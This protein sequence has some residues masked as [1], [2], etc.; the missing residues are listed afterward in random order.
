[1]NFKLLIPIFVLLVLSSIAFAYTG[2]ITMATLNMPANVTV[3]AISGGSLPD[4][5]TYF[6]RIF[7][8]DSWS[9][10]TG[11]DSPWT[12]ELNA[13]T[14]SGS[15]L[16]SIRINWSLI[17]G[18]YKYFPV[19]TT[20]SGDYNETV[21]HCVSRYGLSS[22]TS[23]Y[24]FDAESDLAYYCWYRPDGVPLI[25]V[26]G[27]TSETPISFEDIYQASVENNWSRVFKTGVDSILE[28]GSGNNMS[29]SYVIDANIKMGFGSTTY[30]RQYSA[31]AII[32]GKIYTYDN[33]VELFQLG[34]KAGSGRGGRYG[35]ELEF[36][37]GWNKGVVLGG[38]NVLIYDSVIQ[39]GS[40]SG[41]Q[42]KSWSRP[43]YSHYY[44]HTWGRFHLQLGDNSP[45]DTTLELL[46]SKIGGMWWTV[47]LEAD[48]ALMKWNT[49]T[50]AQE[51]VT[52][53]R[54]MELQDAVI[55]ESSSNAIKLGGNNV[56]FRGV[57]TVYGCNYDLRWHYDGDNDAIYNNLI[58]CT[59]NGRNQITSKGNDDPYGVWYGYNYIEDDIMRFQHEFNP[60][61]I[62]ID[63]NLLEGYNVTLTNVHGVEVI[64][65]YTTSSGVLNGGSIDVTKKE[66]KCNTSRTGYLGSRY[67]SDAI[68]RGDYIEN[69]SNPYTL[70]V[71]KDG[72]DYLTMSFNL[73]SK[74][75]SYIPVDTSP[76]VPGRV[77]IRIG[78]YGGISF[79]LLLIPFTLI[80]WKKRKKR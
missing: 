4:N 65:D 39:I 79:A 45:V 64:D 40:G 37:S 71:S 21:K 76:P 7:G 32:L 14:D 34:D 47:V 24:T 57:E 66:I 72:E 27:G 58:D 15:G 75:D 30:F 74:M 17:S 16:N 10:T 48:T 13:T 46:N 80:Q 33:N 28:Y 35:V 8:A 19:I 62:D 23:S 1:M 51:P 77:G 50:G 53:A 67:L 11:K 31:N 56:T 12:A 42:G 5:T 20:V 78:Q 3:E 36:R 52:I 54:K 38:I 25:S 61:F 29:R 6:V 2:T 69:I 26:D 43:P 59:F 18:T 55:L 68:S 63:G 60:T 9:T 70:K 73:T 41:T 44:D 49:F 22:S